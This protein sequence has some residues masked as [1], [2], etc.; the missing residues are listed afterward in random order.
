M[1]NSCVS[2]SLCICL[3][4]YTACAVLLVFPASLL[5]PINILC[6]ERYKRLLN[7]RRCIARLENPTEHNVPISQTSGNQRGMVALTTTKLV[8]SPR[9]RCFFLF[10]FQAFRSFN[11]PEFRST[12]RRNATTKSLRF[13]AASLSIDPQRN[14]GNVVRTTGGQKPRSQVLRKPIVQSIADR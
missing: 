13:F 3:C 14:R 4:L 8:V 6:R 9:T 7:T 2:P 1:D 5:L 10:K 12:K 11:E